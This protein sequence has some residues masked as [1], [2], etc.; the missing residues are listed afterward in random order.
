MTLEPRRPL[1]RRTEPIV[2]FRGWQQIPQRDGGTGSESRTLTGTNYR[3][4][5]KPGINEAAHMQS[6]YR[7]MIHLPQPCPPHQAPT[8][9][10]ECGFWACSSLEE[11]EATLRDL[12]GGERR[13][14]LGS[15]L[16]WGHVVRH[17]HGYRAQYAMITSLLADRDCS[18]LPQIA[19]H[20]AAPVASGGPELAYLGDYARLGS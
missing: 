18:Q 12:Y 1:A 2:A 3:Y 17:E 14:L 6:P 5:W 15:V 9:R 13:L 10:C 19:E 16:L 11:L 20:Y 4:V 7:G 8:Y